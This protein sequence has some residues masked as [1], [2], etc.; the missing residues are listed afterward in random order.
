MYFCLC[1][2]YM[3]C[4]TVQQCCLRVRVLVYGVFDSTC[5]QLSF[6]L[7]GMMWLQH[8]VTIMCTV[9]C[10]TVLFENEG[11][12]LWSLFDSTRVQLAFIFICDDV[13]TAQCYD[14]VY[15]ILC[16][17]V[18]WEWGSQSI[19]SFWFHMH[20]VSIYFMCDDVTTAQWVCSIAENSTS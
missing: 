9:Y 7:C 8:S 11:V 15:C 10:A 16:N 19:E 17:N 2:D 14:Y 3:Y 18:V 12:S 6:I 20:L 5:I 4:Y 13:T 1:Y